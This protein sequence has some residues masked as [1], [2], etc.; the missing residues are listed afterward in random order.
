[1]DKY[2]YQILGE[3][4]KGSFGTVFKAKKVRANYAIKKVRCDAPENVEL[5]LQEFWTLSCLRAHSNI[6]RFEECYLQHDKN[7]RPLKHGDPTSPA[8]MHLVEMAIKGKRGWGHS[9]YYLWFVMEYCDCGDMNDYLLDREPIA[10]LNTIFMLQ[11]ADGIAFLHKSNVVH[12]DLKPEN[13]LVRK[14]KGRD[15]ILKIADFGLSK[16]CNHPIKDDPDKIVDEDEEND[17]NVDT[18][19]LSSA[20]GS[21]FFMAPEVFEGRYTA[22]ADVFALGIIFWAVMD[23]ITFIDAGTKK[24]L[25]GTYV[26]R[27]KEVL[28]VGEALLDDPNLDMTQLLVDTGVASCSDQRSKRSES[29][30]CVSGNKKKLRDLIVQMVHP[31]PEFRPSSQEL[32]GKLGSILQTGS[33]P[34]KMNLN[35]KKPVEVK[36]ELN[37]EVGISVEDNL[38]DQKQEEKVALEKNPPVEDQPKVETK[39]DEIM[40]KQKSKKTARQKSVA[41]V[42][43]ENIENG[44]QCGRRLR[45][46]KNSCAN[47]KSNPSA[48]KQDESENSTSK[49]ISDTVTKAKRKVLSAV[50]KSENNC[51]GRK[52]PP[53]K[54][55][56]I[57]QDVI[58]N[59]K[60][61]NSDKSSSESEDL[62]SSK[63]ENH[64]I[65]R[66]ELK[67]VITHTSDAMNNSLE[68]DAVHNVRRKSSDKEVQI[69]NGTS[70]ENELEANENKTRLKLRDYVSSPTKISSHDFPDIHGEQ[71]SARNDLS[72]PTE[73][74]EFDEGLGI[75][76]NS[77]DSITPSEVPEFDSGYK[78]KKK[79]RRVSH[80][81]EVET[82]NFSDSSKVDNVIHASED[83]KQQLSINDDST[84]KSG[85]IIE[86]TTDRSISSPNDE[87][88]YE[89]LGMSPFR[90]RHIGLKAQICK[91]KQS[92][93][94]TK[95]SY[96]YAVPSVPE[97]PTEKAMDLTTNSEP[98]FE[99]QNR[100]LKCQERPA[101]LYKV[102]WDSDIILFTLQLK[103]DGNM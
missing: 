9:Q 84:V 51:K 29:R 32:L 54:Q 70:S 78:S 102:E 57:V 30:T 61:G 27:D 88:S 82:T 96:D 89:I 87:D 62:K 99:T 50:K 63:A 45:Q 7:I 18:C 40:K 83:E 28:P 67:S 1:M 5:A 59:S 93:D 11:L 69:S 91:S 60:D 8:Y 95:Q 53:V 58:E 23:R 55:K 26:R 42:Q 15:P 46:R 56:S 72:S 4:G 21:D 92:E 81:T 25:L 13:I 44:S 80:P 34:S 47:N 94:D 66:S 36:P 65:T 64:I 16:V 76:A 37:R 38:P 75:D 100:K 33:R 14:G 10:Y 101:L 90:R 24:V 74:L 79:S 3:I 68:Q 103:N 35:V 2:R 52:K 97:S 48:L 17:I 39:N 31:N 20:C 77:N 85:E 12:R 73:N 41:E 71:N 49:K 19:W 86:N 43:D 6:I 98:I 22:K